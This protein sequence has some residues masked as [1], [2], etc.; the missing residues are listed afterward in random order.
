MLSA[1]QKTARELIRETI[2][3]ENYDICRIT[4][5]AGTGKTYL[6]RELADMVTGMGVNCYVLAPTNR[7]LA[8]LRPALSEVFKD[9]LNSIRTVHSLIYQKPS[10]QISELR[11]DKN[12]LDYILCQLN[13]DSSPKSKTVIIVDEAQLLSDDGFGRLNSIRFGDEDGGHLLNDLLDW[14]FGGGIAGIVVVF[15]G[16]PR[17]AIYKGFERSALCEE[18][19]RSILPNIR[20]LSHDL[21][22][23][24]RFKDSV[25]LGR[26]IEGAKKSLDAKSHHLLWKNSADDSVSISEN[27]LDFLESFVRSWERTL[28]GQKPVLIAEKP[29]A[30][31]DWNNEIRS[32][33]F[34]TTAQVNIADR[35][36]FYNNLSSNGDYQRINGMEG[37]I[38]S[39]SNEVET[40][41]QSLKGR[42]EA[43][44]LSFLDAQVVILPERKIISCKI[45]L[46]YL[47]SEE[48][49]ELKDEWVAIQ[50]WRESAWRKDNPDKKL[51]KELKKEFLLNDPYRN[52]ALVKYGYAITCAKARG[53]EW[54]SVFIAFPKQKVNRQYE[55]WI[56][57]ALSRSKKSLTLLSPPRINPFIKL[58]WAR[59]SDHSK[60]RWSDFPNEFLRYFHVHLL[61]RCNDLGFR[62]KTVSHCGWIEKYIFEME[63]VVIPVDFSYNA[64]GFFTRACIAT[65]V[66]ESAANKIR[67]ALNALY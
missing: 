43:I 2:E 62:V 46:N 51:T 16:D 25:M 20:I 27:R 3:N 63:N 52:A 18:H 4:G 38:I 54:D 60:E 37:E 47:A 28:D 13:A 24:M 40:V 17:Q 15:V 29:G 7:T 1:S 36:I 33:L 31:S 64:K 19:I 11:T 22:D 39:I 59:K 8:Q 56:Y 44:K 23:V 21:T 41:E 42:P 50:A 45:L 49:R 35:I 12:G 48:T 32:K 5:S 55:S 14:S 61:E 26:L 66:S 57:T 9:D 34:S 6:I 10:D 67:A 65:S 30:A 53:W 58:E